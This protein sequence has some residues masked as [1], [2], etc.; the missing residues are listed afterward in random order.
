MPYDDPYTFQWFLEEGV[1]KDLMAEK[2]N[3]SFVSTLVLFLVFWNSKL[4]LAM[5][6]ICFCNCNRFVVEVK[7]MGGGLPAWFVSPCCPPSLVSSFA[8]SSSISVLRGAK[9][10]LVGSSACGHIRGSCT[11]LLITAVLFGTL[12]CLSEG[13]RFCLFCSQNSLGQCFSTFLSPRTSKMAEKIL[14]TTKLCRPIF[15][16]PTWYYQHLGHL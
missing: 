8:H 6:L 2:S 16:K 14:R 3:I 4:S 5:P 1:G 11:L 12:S 7:I 13:F 10:F 9:K 15:F